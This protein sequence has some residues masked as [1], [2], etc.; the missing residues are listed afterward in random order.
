M[1]RSTVAKIRSVS[2]ASTAAA[3]FTLTSF[4]GLMNKLIGGVLH[5]GR[6]DVGLSSSWTWAGEFVSDGIGPV[7][8]KTWGASWD[9]GCS[10]G[11]SGGTFLFVVRLDRA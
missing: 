6:V 9:R 2:S 4:P 5:P 7:R 1:T 8:S 11:L 10:R 3:W